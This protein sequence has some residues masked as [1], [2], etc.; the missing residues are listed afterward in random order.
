M[1]S[2]A[3]PHPRQ[4]LTISPING[5]PPS[6]GSGCGQRRIEARAQGHRPASTWAEHPGAGG[7][8][9]AHSHDPGAAG[10]T[11][12]A[13][14]GVSLGRGGHL[15]PRR[16]RGLPREPS[17]RDHRRSPP[18]GD[19]ARLDDGHRSRLDGLSAH[20]AAIPPSQ[21]S[22][23]GVTGCVAIQRAASGYLPPFLDPNVPGPRR[24]TTRSRQRC[25]NRCR[26]P[27]GAR[28]CCISP[29]SARPQGGCRERHC[30]GLGGIRAQARGRHSSV[31]PLRTC[32]CEQPLCSLR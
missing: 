30:D 7:P 31:Q 26:L 3:E 29:A 27:R 12:A 25:R 9:R 20:P 13:R 1:V 5:N 32:L 28:V 16:R 8:A 11:P 4:P 19:A 2:A 21:H 18:L 22:G 14:R 10:R 24:N 6:V 17:H 23:S 15:R